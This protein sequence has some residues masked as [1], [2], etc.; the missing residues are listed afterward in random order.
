MSAKVSHL[1]AVEEQ[2]AGTCLV[3]RLGTEDVCFVL[4]GLC[5]G[6]EECLVVVCVEVFEI[7]SI[8]KFFVEVCLVEVCFEVCLVEVWLEECLEIV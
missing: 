7:D 4:D 1:C 6:V 8:E 3:V 5:R 2:R